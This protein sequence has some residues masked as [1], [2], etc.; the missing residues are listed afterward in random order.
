MAFADKNKWSNWRIIG[1]IYI[2]STYTVAPL[3]QFVLMSKYPHKCF[4][5]YH[6]KVYVN[7]KRFIVSRADNFANLNLIK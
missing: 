4:A 2:Y 3:L 7:D 5:F 6:K 1:S